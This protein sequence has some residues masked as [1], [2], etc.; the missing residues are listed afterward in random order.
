RAPRNRGRRLH[1]QGRQARVREGRDGH[2][3]RTHDP[4]QEGPGRRSRDRDRAVQGAA[5]GQGRRQGHHREGR[6][7]RQ[8]GRG[9]ARVTTGE[10][11][12]VSASA[13][14][15]NKLRAFLTLLGVIIGVAT[16]VAVVSVISGLNAYVKDKVIGLNPDIVIFDKYGIITSREEWLMAMKRRSLT[17]TDMEIVRRE[18]RLCAQVGARGDRTRPVKYGDKKLSDVEIQGHTPNMGE[19]MSFDIASGRYFTQTEY[20]HDAAVGVI[21]WDVQDQLFPGI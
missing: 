10:L 20:D 6:R 2:R 3:R 13:L 7:R 21:G 12:R 1:R 15:R 14:T 17:M 16:V 18:C 11:F 5:P 8:E 9:Q 19:A 4:G